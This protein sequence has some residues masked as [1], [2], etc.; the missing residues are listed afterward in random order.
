[1]DIRSLRVKSFLA[2]AMTSVLPLLV[3][4][5]YLAERFHSNIEFNAIHELE[6]IAAAKSSEVSTILASIVD[7]A[8]A[9]A[10]SPRV[11]RAAHVAREGGEPRTLVADP[12]YAEAIAMVL[13]IQEASWGRVHH[14]FLVNP[15]GEVI[16]SPGH[17][18]SVA[19]HHGHHIEHPDFRRAVAG[20]TV[21]TDFFGFTE[22]DHFHQLVMVPVRADNGAVCG[23]IVVE[24]TIEYMLG[25][26]ARGIPSDRTS[27]RLL[28]PDG[29]AIVHARDALVE[30][31]VHQN[32][33]E[34]MSDGAYAGRAVRADGTPVLTVYRTSEDGSFVLMTEQDLSTVTASVRTAMLGAGAIF[35]PI[36]IVVL[37][38]AHLVSKRM[39]RPINQMAATLRDIS[40]GSGDLSQRV[41]VP[42]TT[43]LG[44]MASSF[45]SF[46][47]KIND[48]VASVAG[49]SAEIRA[50]CGQIA[51]MSRTAATEFQSYGLRLDEM[52]TAVS[53][54]ARSLAEVAD[55]TEQL[56]RDSAE[57][58]TLAQEG[59][60]VIGRG[61]GE[62]NGIA[63]D[64]GKTSERVVE[65][66]KIGEL[67]YELVGTIDDVADQTNLLAL[68]AAIEAARAGEH[69]RGFAVVADEVRKLA[70]RTTSIT[71]EISG[72]IGQLR[73]A[74]T[75]VAQRTEACV[76]RANRGAKGSGE[77]AGRLEA[78][79]HS[80]GRTN[81]SVN[82]VGQATARQAAATEEISSSLISVTEG[83]TMAVSQ[84]DSTASA[85]ELIAT[86]SEQL[87][88][89]MKQ[90]RLHAQDRRA[91]QTPAQ[92]AGW[93]DKR[94]HM[95][96]RIGELV[97]G[98][99]RER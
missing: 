70:D 74:T 97:R 19:S 34:A 71:A 93:A 40:S 7:D 3:I 67:I 63:E 31:V 81:G 49:A 48:L 47:Q 53:D 45:N 94:L 61:L 35:V 38:M 57:A 21:L 20:E 29:V 77:A 27:V 4:G 44:D 39:V 75:E 72:S 23:V 96:R 33:V 25:Q 42:Q 56:Q 65:L 98:K 16:L 69:G 2:L 66:N 6:T 89:L 15:D 92:A 84:A 54:N 46:A 10:S 79:M 73:T 5:A 36:L 26:M 50:G 9:L 76:V 95:S 91:N 12:D 52:S 37:V 1:M 41:E 78:I 17:G 85:V 32:F 58:G 59:A 62:M 99:H 82:E 80:M 43:E 55:R 24:V 83:M 68:N 64:I 14:I 90:F 18:G 30:E 88:G 11:V 13:A 86:K 22:K 51:E 8:E 87:D 60:E 28:T